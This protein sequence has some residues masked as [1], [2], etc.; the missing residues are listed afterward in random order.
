MPVNQNGDGFLVWNH[1]S[2]WRGFVGSVDRILSGKATV[3]LACASRSFYFPIWLLLLSPDLVTSM[4]LPVARH[5][6][7]AD[8]PSNRRASGACEP[9]DSFLIKPLTWIHHWV[10]GEMGHLFPSLNRQSNSY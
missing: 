8:P 1:E 3:L 5:D 4:G 6:S 2:R 9:L 7:K 10:Q